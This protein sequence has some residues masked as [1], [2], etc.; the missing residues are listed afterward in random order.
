MQW[1]SAYG[2]WDLLYR[3]VTALQIAQ[4]DKVGP[5]RISTAIKYIDKLTSIGALDWDDQIG[6]PPPIPSAGFHEQIFRRLIIKG[7]KLVISI[8]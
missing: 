6:N 3:V 5:R 1:Y 4:P 2:F 8:S 7:A